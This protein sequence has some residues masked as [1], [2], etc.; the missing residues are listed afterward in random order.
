QTGVMQ[1]V[2]IEDMFNLAHAFSCQPLPSGSNVAIV[3][4]S[5]TLNISRPSS[6]TLEKMKEV[7]P[8][9]ASLYNPIDMLG[10]A[11]ADTYHKVLRAVAEDDV[12]HSILVILT[13][14]ANILEDVEKAAADIIEL[15]KEC[16]KPIITC[17]MG[18]HSTRKAR[19]M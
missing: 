16:D 11:N 14:A 2:D 13:P 8:R 18:D 12:F 4:N 15:E 1:A 9:Y 3:T 7:L 17:F 10:D 5:G 6:V 19:R